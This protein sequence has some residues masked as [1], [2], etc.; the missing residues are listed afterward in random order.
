M[1]QIGNSVFSDGMLRKV[2][3][4][5][6]VALALVLTSRFVAAESVADVVEWPPA[7][8]ELFGN[9]EIVTKPG[10]EKVRIFG[11]GNYGPFDGIERNAVR[12]KVTVG[13]SGKDREVHLA[14]AFSRRFYVETLSKRSRSH[15]ER[16]LK[17]GELIDLTEDDFV[18]LSTRMLLG[19]RAGAKHLD[20]WWKVRM[21]LPLTPDHRQ[22]LLVTVIHTNLSAEKMKE[23]VG[24]LSIGLREKGGDPGGDFIIDFRAQWNLDRVPKVIEGFNFGNELKLAGF[25]AN[26]YDWL[27]TQAEYRNCYVDLWFLP[28]YQEQVTLLRHFRSEISPHNAGNFRAFRKNCTSLALLFFDRLRPI[29][30]PGPASRDFADFPVAGAEKILSCYGEVPLYQLS[31]ITD[32]LG[33][34]QTAKSEIHRAVPT[35]ATSR[36]FRLLAAEPNLN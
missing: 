36:S 24:H 7:F 35:R 13:A 9:P 33:R 26:L 8:A 1:I 22:H 25:T 10:I 31:A 18:A 12:S 4:A 34:Q 2:Q 27:A 21:G 20:A 15:Y 19:G 23:T 6:M 5:G 14:Q 16:R 29:S 30:E 32:E 17:M 28:V 11:A 3:T